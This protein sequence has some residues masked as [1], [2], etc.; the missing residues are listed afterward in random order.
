MDF[1]DF[2][3]TDNG[4]LYPE[5]RLFVEILKTYYLDID[6]LASYKNLG[7]SEFKRK[8]TLKQ[9]RATHPVYRLNQIL[10]HLYSPYTEYYC[11]LINIDVNYFRESVVNYIRQKLKVTIVFDEYSASHQAI[12]TLDSSDEPEPEL[13]VSIHKAPFF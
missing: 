4:E 3:T 8:I 9:K 1:E 2:N 6:Y 10:M 5:Y 12:E 11:D 13:E 7:E